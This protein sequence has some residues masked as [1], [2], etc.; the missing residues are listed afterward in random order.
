MAGIH[1]AAFEAVDEAAVR[2]QVFYHHAQIRLIK[3]VKDLVQGFLD[4]F[5]Q[6]GLVLDDGLNLQRHVA[7][8]HGQGEVFHR[9][10]TGNALGPLALGI[11][12]AVQDALEGFAG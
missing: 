2:G 10:G 12:P 6:Q 4:G 11:G 3:H 8:D 9:P 1:A 7:D 5:V